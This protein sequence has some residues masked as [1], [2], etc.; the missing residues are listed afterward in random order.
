MH[1][2]GEVLPENDVLVDNREYFTLS[3]L[4]NRDNNT[5]SYYRF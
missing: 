4:K 1:K 3:A 5:A 2:K